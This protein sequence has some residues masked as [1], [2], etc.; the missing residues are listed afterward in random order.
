MLIHANCKPHFSPSSFFPDL[1]R[2]THT[3]LITCF[4]ALNPTKL[5]LSSINVSTCCN[6]QFLS[7]AWSLVASQSRQQ[8]SKRFAL[9]LLT[10]AMLYSDLWF[11]V[12]HKCENPSTK[13]WEL[14]VTSLW[15]TCTKFLLVCVP[16]SIPPL[17]IIVFWTVSYCFP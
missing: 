11:F 16:S 4:Y 3:L 14:P 12:Y 13:G 17:H 9:Q 7:L 2:M 1:H 5:S 15:M 6:P 8:L 10:Y